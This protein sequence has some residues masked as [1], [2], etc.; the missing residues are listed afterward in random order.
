MAI[1]RPVRRLPLPAATLA[2]AGQLARQALGPIAG[3]TV[4]IVS[5]ATSYLAQRAAA[6]A[7]GQWSEMDV[8]A[9]GLNSGN[10]RPLESVLDDAAID[11]TNKAGW[12]PVTGRVII[13]SEGA[14]APGPMLTWYDAATDTWGRGAPYPSQI[15]HGYDNQAINVAGRRYYKTKYPGGVVLQVDLD[16]DLAAAPYLAE[17]GG[18]PRG[19]DFHGAAFHPS[20]GAQGS[21][22][23]VANG[24]AILRY[25]V[26]SGVW[27]TLASGLNISGY[28][29]M[30]VYH[31]GMDVVACGPGDGT[32]VTSDIYL[33]SAAGA[34]TLLAQSGR[35]YAK[36]NFIHDLFDTSG[37]LC[38]PSPRNN[39]L[40]F[41]FEGGPGDV[42][43][44]DLASG[45]WAARAQAP[46]P[47][48]AQGFGYA[49]VVPIE[50][51]AV[52]M[53]VQYVAG[54]GSRVFLHKP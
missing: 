27:T 5:T 16:A 40:I 32:G 34:V 18:A 3:A 26:A 13:V 11:W 49:L 9:T 44:L 25:D 21:L 19:I 54:G 10:P 7:V 15:G 31:P 42:Y 50:T 12:D 22:V 41:Y 17:I 35:P 33:V 47:F 36:L 2:G 28:H 30:A 48:S 43:A 53:I 52:H 29:T 14:G 51:Y 4:Q 23:H 38:A 6:L 39:E 8:S 46:A 24:G 1:I 45:A 37:A 20:L